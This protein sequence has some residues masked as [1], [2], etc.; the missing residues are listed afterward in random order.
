MAVVQNMA[1]II[2]LIKKV[3]EGDDE[4]FASIVALYTPMMQK[5]AGSYSLDYDEVFGELCMSLYRATLTYDIEQSAV[6]FGL[7]ARILAVRSMCDQL[8]LRQREELV[9]SSGDIDEIAVDGGVDTALIRKE[10]N[11]IFRRDARELLSEYEYSVLIRWL[12]GDKTAAISDALGVS[13]KSVDNAKARI[14]K[15]L[16]DGLKPFG[17]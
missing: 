13:A 14:L 12:G 4:A 1:D 2:T 10:E 8:R 6:T 16:R 3:R 17:A 11:E 5:V 9:E 15:K 7:Y